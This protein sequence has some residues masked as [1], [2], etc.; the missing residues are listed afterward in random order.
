VFGVI[1]FLIEF[2]AS[3]LKNCGK[4]AKQIYFLGVWANYFSALI[5]GGQFCI[6]YWVLVFVFLA[7][8]AVI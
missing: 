4:C 5:M 3:G 1:V 8:S 7:L 2:R 6:S